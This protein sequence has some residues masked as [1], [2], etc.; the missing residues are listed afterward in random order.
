[1]IE[2]F[3][4]DYP[5]IPARVVDARELHTVSDLQKGQFTKVFSNAA[6]HWILRDAS[7]RTTV[8]KSVYDA[9]QPGGAFVAEMGGYGNIA[10]I[11]SAITLE[12]IHR[13]VPADK[14]IEAC[15]W[16]FPSVETMRTL[17]EDSG[18]VWAKGEAEWRQTVLTEGKEGGIKGW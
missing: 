10:E 5:S 4:R 7:A 12:L 13:G 6:L 15:P 16:Y 8:I 14:A 9:L 18:L 3:Q 2:A 1:M 17:L 11:H